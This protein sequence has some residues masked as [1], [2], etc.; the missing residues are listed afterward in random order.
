MHSVLLEAEL[1]VNPVEILSCLGQKRY[2]NPRCS[3]LTKGKYHGGIAKYF[4][5]PGQKEVSIRLLSDKAF[6]PLLVCFCKKP[7]KAGE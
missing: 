2:W 3:Q 5:H 6:L 4:H 1:P 7:K